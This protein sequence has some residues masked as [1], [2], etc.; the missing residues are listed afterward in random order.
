MVA[1]VLTYERVRCCG[2]S[3]HS[4]SDICVRRAYVMRRTCIESLE[5]RHR[6]GA[7]RSVAA[8]LALMSLELELG[9]DRVDGRDRFA[10]FKLHTPMCCVSI[11]SAR[12]QRQR[13][14]CVD[15]VDMRT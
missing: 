4:G 11:S 7:K 9:V 5:K 14:R 2:E 6:Q 12:L 13:T 8:Q 3:G 1:A 10:T 15:V